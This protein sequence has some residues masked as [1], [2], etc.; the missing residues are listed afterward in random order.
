[1]SRIPTI[2]ADGRGRKIAALAGFALG[3]AGAAG[4]GAFATRD[5]FAA[6]RADDPQ[7]AIAPIAAIAAA[8][9]AIAGLR[10]CERVSAERIGQE[11]AA[12]LREKLFVHVSGM[13]ASA[14]ANYRAGGLALRF[15]GDLSAVRG[16]VSLGLGRLISSAI[17]L[18]A[19]AVILLALNPALGV[20]AIAPIAVGVALMCLAGWRLAATHR[21]LRAKRSRL[22]A[23]MSERIACAPELRLMGRLDIERRKLRER[24]SKLMDAAI[25]RAKG[26]GVLDAIP[27]AAA[28]LAIAALFAAAILSGAAAAEIAGCMAALSV[29][30]HPMR[31]LAG[32]WDRHRAF[33]AARAKCERLLSAPRLKRKR[34]RPAQALPSERANTVGAHVE[35]ENV[36]AGSLKN[37]SA[38]VAPGARIALLGANGAGKSTLLALAA[39]LEQPAKGSVSIHGVSPASMTASERRRAIAY[40]GARSPILAG[41]MRRALTMGCATRPSDEIIL[42]RAD[43]FG[44]LCAIERLGGL[45]GVVREGARN[46]SA[47]QARRLMLVRAALARP[48]LLLLDEPDDVLDPKGVDL[49]VRLL[50][51]TKSTALIATHNI[52]T[53]RMA[54]ELWLVRDGAIADIDKP[55]TISSAGGPIADFFRIRS[56][57]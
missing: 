32:V 11:Y 48:K 14:I 6:V 35:F 19:A 25:H 36:T 26:A 13:P 40:V 47:G 52:R 57:A 54:D 22:A 45:D 43:E 23:D 2:A 4:V 55:D 8:G 41:T 27:D 20:A 5:V 21:R 9:L 24:T 31:R 30:T 34:T 3:Q 16:W 56:A 28:G 37:V 51:A 18:P 15:V 33:I 29:L 50:D 17:A 12:A 7:A 46:L 42:K 53:A 44:L 38:K 39:G 49:L 10:I 1:M